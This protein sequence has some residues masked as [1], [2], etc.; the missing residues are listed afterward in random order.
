MTE[1]PNAPPVAIFPGPTG[2]ALRFRSPT[3]VLSTSTR[4]DRKLVTPQDQVVLGGKRIRIVV[5]R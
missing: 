5:V 1:P 4:V 3:A 2:Q